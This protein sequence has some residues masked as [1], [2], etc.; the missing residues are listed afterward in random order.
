MFCCRTAPTAVSK[1]SVINHVGASDWGDDSID[2]LASSSF[3]ELKA[4]SAASVPGT[5][6]CLLRGEREE[7]VHSGEGNGGK[8]SRVQ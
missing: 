7:A 4:V 1:A 2:A 8:N 5:W 3:V 6:V